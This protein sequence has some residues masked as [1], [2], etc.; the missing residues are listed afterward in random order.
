MKAPGAP[1]S[2]TTPSNVF[3]AEEVAERKAFLEFGPRDGE[4]LLALHE[5]IEPA[6]GAFTESFY[7]HILTFEP[8]RRLMPDDQSLRRLRGAQSAY[9]SQLTA[10]DYGETYVANRLQV[11]QMHQRI[12][13]APKWYIGAYRKYLSG[14]MP[15]V[16]AECDGD[17]EHFLASYDSLLKIVLFDMGLALDSYFQAEHRQLQEMKDYADRVIC[18]MPSGLMVLDAGLRLRTINLAAR[19]MLGL[20]ELDDLQG[21]ALDGLLPNPALLELAREVLHMRQASRSLVVGP[22]PE[23]AGRILS[24]TLSAS[25]IEETPVLIVQI[26]DETESVRA[27]A[28]LARFRAALDAT[29]DAIFLIDRARMRFVDVNE[30]ACSQLGYSRSELL[31]MG[32]QDIKPLLTEAELAARFDRVRGEAGGVGRL[33]TLHQRHDG[34]TFPVELSL[35]G[36]I[37]EGRKMLVAVARDIS[38][39]KQ[40]EAALKESEERFRATFQQ[41][42]VGIAHIAPDGRW[43]RVNDKLCA[44][45]EHPR[46]ELLRQ[47]FQAITHT[48]DLARELALMR[49][50]MDGESDSYRLEKRFLRADGKPVW[51]GVTVSLARTPSGQPKYFI[52]VIEDISARKNTEESLRLA[53]RALE[54]SGNGIVITDCRQPDNPI[55][56]VN[57]AFERITGYSAAE[58][59]GRNCRFLHGEDHSQAGTRALGEAVANTREAKVVV[60]N[61]RKDGRLFW[62]ELLI[63]P[64]RA[65]DGSVTH[66]VGV[67]NDISEQKQAEESLLHMATHD[68]L[69]GLPNRNLLQ[70]RIAQAIGYADRLRHEVA[71]LFIDID[72]FKNINDSLGHTVGDT[73]ITTLAQRLRGAVRAVDTVARVGGDEFV[74]VLTDIQHEADVNQVISGLVASISQPVPVDG[75]ALTVTASIGVSLYPHD[76]RDVTS[77]LKNADTAMYRAKDAGRNSYRFYTQEMNADAVARLRLES[78]LRNAIQGEELLVYYQPQVDVESG[79]IV[80]AEALLR[81]RHPSHGLV[82]PAEFIPLA[83]ETG[84]IVPIGEWVLRQVCAQIRAWR[85]AALPEVRVAVNLSPRQFRQPNLVEMIVGAVRDYEL[86]ASCLELEITEGSL[87]HNPEEAERL[88]TELAHHGFDLSVDDF[89]TGYSSLAYLKRFPLHA[90][91]IDRS[92]VSDIETN[93]ESAAIAAGV[94]ALAHSLNLKVVA[95]GVEQQGQAAYL[96]AQ[97]C[98]FIQGY[99]YGRPMPAEE[100]TARVETQACPTSS[101]PQ[102]HTIRS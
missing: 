61:Y 20:L 17:V 62:N 9:F 86:P 95:E 68:A 98:D 40:A 48:E 83:E 59:L 36:F 37:S 91:K 93:R 7:S 79:H 89:G 6:R 100:F 87:M 39:R 57:P 47:D 54:A 29:D 32:P 60:R 82:S 51:T 1:T 30:T 11:G 8:M 85:E 28:Y 31:T 46:E 84:L 67:Q 64:V 78:D 23:L 74:V 88:L 33:E 65:E 75:H 99:L 70:D 49:Q 43:L 12:G 14:L 71:I 2:G 15:L 24:L 58:A 55:V 80:A 4:R 96:R 16:W 41:A 44:I 94:I 77:L 76:G 42:A 25:T 52:A 38:Q 10:G 63:A 56:Y 13:L 3:D 66:F 90:L 69:T 27:E 92:F 45:V 102:S 72:R 26:E 18:S 5:R 22:L 21:R 34:S 19:D 50:A 73:L 81:W 101:I 53:Q 35:H 97:R